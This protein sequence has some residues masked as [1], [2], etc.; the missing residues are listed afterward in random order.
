MCLIPCATPLRRNSKSSPVTR[1]SAMLSL[2]AAMSMTGANVPLVKL[3]LASVP[4]GV[5]LT[6]RFLLAAIVLAMLARHEPGPRLGSLRARQWGA[7]AVLGVV[8][9]V[10][11][12]WFVLEGVRRTSGASAG[13]I[14]SALPA[15][16]AFAG[17]ARGERLSRGEVA[18]IALAVAGVA[19]IQG[20]PSAATANGGATSA[21]LGNLLIACAVLCEAAFVLVARRISTEIGP[22]RLSLAV[23]LVGLIVCAPFGVSAWSAYAWRMLDVGTILLFIWYALTAS[24]VCTALWYRGVAHVETWTAGLATTAVPVSALAVSVLVLG[25][26]L[27]TAQLA[28]AA[29]VIA[30]ILAGTLSRSE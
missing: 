9:S 6:A 5:I 28:G 11:F 10:L 18:M 17:F 12:T 2:V 8:G 27:S 20:Q 25:E 1:D 23:A 19:L 26:P 14:L 24:V 16:V 7:I 29:L 22:M 4:P 30:A 15:V 13:I 21:W 3:L